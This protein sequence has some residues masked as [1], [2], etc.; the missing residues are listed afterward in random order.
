[1]VSKRNTKKSKFN[2]TAILA[3][4]SA[5][6][7]IV[8][9]AWQIILAD[10]SN[11]IAAQHLSS[12]QKIDSERSNALYDKRRVE[13]L[14]KTCTRTAKGE[15]EA[16]I[17][18]DRLFELVKSGQRSIRGTGEANPFCKASDFI[19]EYNLDSGY[20]DTFVWMENSTSEGVK[21]ICTCST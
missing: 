3:I 10:K 1:M 7:A 15:P 14:I 5:I 20:S 16:A 11:D 2:L 21:I 12:N 13:S 19:S 6:A 17:I 4:S 8:F 9:G 18:A